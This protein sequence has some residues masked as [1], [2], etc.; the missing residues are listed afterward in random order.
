[1]VESLLEYRS[2][3][4]QK[5]VF[6]P[7]CGAFGGTVAPN[8]EWKRKQQFVHSNEVLYTTISLFHMIDLI[9]PAAPI[10]LPSSPDFSVWHLRLLV[11]AGTHLFWLLAPNFFHVPCALAKR[12]FCMLSHLWV[13]LL[14]CLLPGMLF[15][16]PPLSF[17]YSWSHP[18]SI[19]SNLLQLSAPCIPLPLS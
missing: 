10:S 9:Q 17:K 4:V 5:V 13:C 16:H 3:W 2:V 7:L 15:S 18:W 1:M 19:L 11:L 14:L 8:T 6:F 12:G